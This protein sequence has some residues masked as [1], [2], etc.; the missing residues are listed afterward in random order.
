MV[1]AEFIIDDLPSM[2]NRSSGRHWSI[3]ARE[4]VK[5]QRLVDVHVD[6]FKLRGL[7]LEKIK[8]T[9]V[10]FSSK[11]PD[12]DGLVSG[13]KIV[14]DSLVK[15]GVMVDDNMKVTGIPFCDWS[16]RPT[17]QGGRISVKIEGSTL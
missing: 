14:M 13:F 1:L 6:K 8:L 9:F 5:W 15:S 16:Y 4:R 2:T 3:R 11:A 12:Y 10:R 7:G 17:K